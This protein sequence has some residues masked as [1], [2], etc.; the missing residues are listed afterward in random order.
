MKRHVHDNH[1]REWFNL[2]L[3]GGLLLFCLCSSAAEYQW[4]VPVASVISDETKEP[5]RAFLWIPPTCGRVRAVVV[6]QHNMLEEPLFEN[7][8][9]RA[10]LAELGIAEVWISPSLC[11]QAQFGE[12]EQGQFE[13]MFRLLAAESGYVELVQAPVVAVGHSAMAD[14]PYLYAAHNPERTL[15]AVSLKGSWPDLTK[16]CFR[17]ISDKLKG[18]PLL[19]VS[20]E[21]EW[22]DERAGKSLAFRR[23]YPGV[24]FS[25]LAD[26]GGGHFD[27]HDALAAFLA[28]YL[29]SA[30]KARLPDVSG[31]FTAPVVLKAVDPLKQGWLVDRWRMN[32][33]P[34]AP[35]A[36]VGTY[37]G[38]RDETFWCFDE[39]HA[40][41]TERMQS[42]YQGKQADLLGYVQ[43][44]KI[45]GQEPRLHAQVRL[46]FLPEADGRTFKLTGAFLATVP[47]G[48]PA[49]W[50]GLAAGTPVGHATGGGPVVI[51]R[52][53]GPVEKV[54]VDTFAVSFN[55]MG[56]NNVRRSNEIWLMATHPGDA[57]YKR[58]VQQAVM[59]IPRRNE[60]GAEQRITFPQIPDQKLGTWSVVLHA[61]SDAGVPVSYYVREGPARL[62][63]STLE[64]TAIPPRAKFPVKVTVVAWQYGRT[65]DP[66]LKSAAPVER[67][68]QIT[69]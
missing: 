8:A 59:T 35:A 29:R 64:L 51:D 40:R 57:E 13:E 65:S 1:L 38:G 6:G 17:G 66:R 32:K 56:M 60:Q 14:F 50:T 45:L 61:T 48:R 22:A 43:E 21:Y 11:G 7:P 49:R 69:K 44:G 15:S 55:R 12:K 16:P 23:T 20:G 26:A 62:A 53:C 46:K 67:T 36:S 3:T 58:A 41:A 54:G 63:G 2:G 25:M 28:V 9:F 30:V 52:I 31:P 37:T 10:A 24:P 47:E 42:A 18:V 4:S 39:E 68:F 27:M 5:P 33:L 34:R 19:L